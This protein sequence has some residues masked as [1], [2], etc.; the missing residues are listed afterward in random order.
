MRGCSIREGVAFILL[1]L[2]MGFMDSDTVFIPGTI[3]I[4][5]GLALL[6]MAGEREGHAGQARS[7]NINICA[8]IMV[9]GKEDRTMGYRICPYCGASL[10]PDER[11]DCRDGIATSQKENEPAGGDHTGSENVTDGIYYIT[12]KGERQ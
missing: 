8:V 10:D 12:E 7:Q 11:C 4:L 3:C 5:S 2:S 1:M 9:Q 6:W